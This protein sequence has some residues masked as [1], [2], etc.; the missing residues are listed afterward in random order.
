MATPVSLHNQRFW[1][2]SSHVHMNYSGSKRLSAAQQQSSP[3]PDRA[4]KPSRKPSSRSSSHVVDDQTAKTVEIISIPSDEESD[5]EGDS[6]DNEP[7]ERLTH[8]SYRSNPASILRQGSMMPV[9]TKSPRMLTWDECTGAVDNHEASADGV[10]QERTMD[11]AHASPS[12]RARSVVRDEDADSEQTSASSGR[13]FSAGLHY[14]PRQIEK[15]PTSKS[16]SNTADNSEHAHPDDTLPSVE[17]F[18]ASAKEQA[19]DTHRVGEHNR[20]TNR[21]D[22]HEGVGAPSSPSAP[23]YQAAPRSLSP[24]SA[25]STTS[26]AASPFHSPRTPGST[27]ASTPAVS[28]QANMSFKNLSCDLEPMQISSSQLATEDVM[29]TLGDPSP[30]PPQLPDSSDVE[31][32]IHVQING[33]NMESRSGLSL[34]QRRTQPT[35]INEKSQWR[36]RDDSHRQ[37]GVRSQSDTEYCPSSTDDENQD[38]DRQD[39]DE[40]GVFQQDSRKR[41]KSGR[42]SVRPRW[43]SKRHCPDTSTRER[44][45]RDMLPS[46]ISPPSTDCIDGVRAEFEEWALHNVRLKRTI[47]NDRATFQLQFDWDLCMKHGHVVHPRSKR[48]QKPGP[49]ARARFTQEEDCLLIQLK[50]ELKLSWADIH[51]RFSGRFAWR[52]KEALQVRYCTK[53]KCRG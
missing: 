50:E 41:R 24:A 23:T 44:R 52:S 14:T 2:P 22:G 35:A 42:P 26:S 37:D 29:N 48:G 20:Q 36:H 49:S 19:G 1:T 18:A 25:Q 27:R 47:V 53:L 10:F 34:S 15:A 39:S 38:D 8:V 17:A 21:D 11:T 51:A 7:Q 46:D 6:H 12:P 28:Q 45:P 4:E 32:N 33:K 9:C 5:V 13:Q 3:S 40:D 16:L 31:P 43:P 30:V